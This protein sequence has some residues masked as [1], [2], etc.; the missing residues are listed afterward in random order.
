M[1][2]QKTTATLLLVVSLASVNAT[3]YI[4][5]GN[6]ARNPYDSNGRL[7]PRTTL[8][9]TSFNPGDLSESYQETQN[10]IHEARERINCSSQEINRSMT[11]AEEEMR[12]TANG[13]PPSNGNIDLSS[14]S[15]SSGLTGTPFSNGQNSRSDLQNAANPFNDFSDEEQE[16]RRLTGLF[17]STEGIVGRGMSNVGGSS[18]G[19]E[20]NRNF[21]I[22][23]SNETNPL[24]NNYHTS[25]QSNLRSFSG[26]NEESDLDDFYLPTLDNFGT[27]LND[28][29]P[30]RLTS[31]PA[32]SRTFINPRT[33]SRQR[34]A[35]LDMNSSTGLN[36]NISYVASYKIPKHVPWILTI[37]A[38]FTIIS[39]ILSIIYAQKEDKLN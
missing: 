17:A 14:F 11:Q 39:I 29:T 35:R 12:R 21:G 23:N 10:R 16:R 25:T 3:G 8:R 4:P 31:R 20:T 7:F 2:F 24:G 9:P 13:I 22:F 32:S 19:P 26:D 38:G 36:N 33:Q 6:R 27:R 30:I 5:N 1:N 37:L 15:G 28:S 34:S 18:L